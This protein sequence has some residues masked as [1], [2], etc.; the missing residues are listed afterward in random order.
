MHAGH[1]IDGAGH[2]NHHGDYCSNGRAGYPGLDDE[3]QVIIR[4]DKELRP[5]FLF[6][7]S[8]VNVQGEVGRYGRIV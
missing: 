4:I 5:L 2:A 1:G 8:A 6:F 3:L 7:L